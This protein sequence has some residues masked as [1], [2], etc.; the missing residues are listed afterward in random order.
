MLKTLCHTHLDNE[1]QLKSNV[2]SKLCK[3]LRIQQTFL[4]PY[5]HKRNGLINACSEQ[6]NT[7][8]TLCANNQRWIKEL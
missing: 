5:Y 1:S 2:M 8:F 3:I 7:S 4:F 6:S